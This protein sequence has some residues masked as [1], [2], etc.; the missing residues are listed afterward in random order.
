[1]PSA[2]GDPRTSRRQ[3]ADYGRADSLAPAG[4][5]GTAP[6]QIQI[7]GVPSFPMPASL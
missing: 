6:R 3:P 2:Y 7:H 1:M 5:D 4:D